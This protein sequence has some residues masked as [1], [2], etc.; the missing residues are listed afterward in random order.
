MVA[1]SAAGDIVAKLVVV[2]EEVGTGVVV[3]LSTDGPALGLHARC[4]L[5]PGK[6]LV[7]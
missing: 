1:G 7:G 5:P 3:G 6:A 4:S 2:E